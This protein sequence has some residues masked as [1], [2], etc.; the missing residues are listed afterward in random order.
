MLE[1]NSAPDGFSAG[2]EHIFIA[3]PLALD[4]R[5][6]AAYIISNEAIRL[7][8]DEF[9]TLYILASRKD[10]DLSFE[11]LYNAVWEMEDGRDRRWEAKKGIAGVM[12]AINSAG[13]DFV[14]IEHNP[15]DSYVLRAR[16]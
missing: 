7:N 10:M 8:S 5:A 16:W 1:R 12:A 4:G 13:N 2:T 6:N 14:W 9:E 11:L 3:G 15:P